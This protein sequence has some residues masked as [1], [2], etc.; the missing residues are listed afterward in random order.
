MPNQTCLQ[1][2]AGVRTRGGNGLTTRVLNKGI[3]RGYTPLCLAEKDKRLRPLGH[4]EVRACAARGA[5]A[6]YC[7]KRGERSGE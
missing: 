6:P 4:D 5:I 2:R 7:A 1:R 3:L